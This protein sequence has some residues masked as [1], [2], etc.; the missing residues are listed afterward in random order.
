MPPGEINWREIDSA[1]RRLDCPFG[2]APFGYAQDL[3]QDKPGVGSLWAKNAFVTQ[4]NIRRLN[5]VAGV[6]V[7][8]PNH[9]PGRTRPY[10]PDD[11]SHRVESKNAIRTRCV[12]PHESR[13]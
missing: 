1:C 13:N 6:V 12:Y 8:A 5:G 2:R 7:V 3:R 9:L 11:I 4:A 10:G